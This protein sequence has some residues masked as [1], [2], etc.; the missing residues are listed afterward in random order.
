M[1]QIDMKSLAVMIEQIDGLT[2]TNDVTP[3]EDEFITGIVERLP[4]N[5]DTRG[6]SAKQVEIIER[7][8]GKHFA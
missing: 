8:W 6:Y 2:G 4:A 5:K 1:D 3:W 7:I